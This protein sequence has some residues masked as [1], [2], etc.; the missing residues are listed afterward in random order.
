[1]RALI[2]ISWALSF[3]VPAAASSHQDKKRIAAIEERLDQIHDAHERIRRDKAK[4]P[5]DVHGRTMA[6]DI[7][8]WA[9]TRELDQNVKALLATARTA[10]SAQAN[11]SLDEASLMLDDARTH[12]TQILMYWSQLSGS[13][14]RARWKSFAE[15]N[16]I[17]PEAADAKIVAA[18][19]TIQEY[20]DRGDFVDAAS[21]SASL[22]SDL[23]ATI[24]SS[25]TALLQANNSAPKFI[26]RATPCPGTDGA[27]RNARLTQAASPDDYY[28]PGSKRRE[29]QGDIVIRAH[30][31]AAGCASEFAVLVRSGFVD[32]DEAALKVAEASRYAAATDDGLPHD[33]Y[34]TFKVRFTLK[35]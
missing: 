24:R 19:S 28:P 7:D 11:A 6:D 21:A 10:D 1:L 33:G 34:V 23:R 26:P 31:T 22:E 2:V 5:I 4:S 17:P 16:Q 9:Y 3:V 14:W 20:L 30:V 32:L 27:A 15:S 18:E 25:T 8:K 13:N 35:P 12:A 29:E